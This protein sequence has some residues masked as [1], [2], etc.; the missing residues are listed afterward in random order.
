[1]LKKLYLKYGNRS[2]YSK[3]SIIIWGLT[4]TITLVAVLTSVIYY[5]YMANNKLLDTAKSSAQNAVNTIDINYT[6]IIERFVAAC[7]TEEFAAI[8]KTFISPNTSRTAREDMVQEVLN[9]LF[10]CNYMV[11]SALILSSDRKEYF[12]PYKNP[13]RTN[14]L[15]LFSEEELAS[16]DGITWLPERKSPFRNSVNV[17]PVVFPI[18][19]T[20]NGFTAISTSAE[21]PD[22]YVII[23]IESVKLTYSLALSGDLNT[24]STFF[25]VSPEGELF[26]SRSGEVAQ[27]VLANKEVF[28]FLK[29]F[30]FS[31]KANDHYNHPHYYLIASKL[32]RMDLLLVSFV[33][34]EHFAAM[35]GWTGVIILIVLLVIIL[36]MVIVSFLMAHY[37]TRPLNTLMKVVSQIGNNEYTQHIQ[38]ST[39]DEMGELCRAINSMHDTIQKQ[40]EQIKQEEAKKYM[41]EIKLLA[42]QI[43][44][45]F[46]YNTL[47]CIQ[48]EVIG[49][50][51]Q[52]AANMIQYLAEYLRIG[53]SYGD[54][55]IT[56]ANEL[57]HV[58]AYIKILNQRFQQSIIFMYQAEP[59]LDRHYMLKTILQPLVEN[60][61][62]YGFSIDGYGSVPISSPTIEI[63]FYTR[64]DLLHIEVI[65][66]GAGFDVEKTKEI[67][68]HD[69][70][71]DGS[72]HVGLHNIY[73][74]LV[75]YY[76][77]DQVAFELSSI[78][79]YRNSILMRFPLTREKQQEQSNIL[80][81]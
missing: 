70:N 67:L 38:F 59:G 44:P 32:E 36:I 21:D 10:N 8:F 23:L 12:S 34:K 57:R 50:R 5:R 68:Y 62:K 61:I 4:L 75:T 48:L 40:M 42:E 73:Y 74:R 25:I 14:L 65:D 2:L 55:L 77:E 27:K 26:N 60:S 49:G 45:H 22:A 72:R 71:S 29:N 31:S 3:I 33:E 41:S 39:N 20:D 43:N 58:H 76:G 6:D 1:M 52:S 9:T 37:I 7:G 66:N 16:I 79:Y 18:H 28:T 56:I 47:E 15:P 78:P 53:L 51:P 11:N 64:E 54:D 63:H 17:I 30:S 81:N 46:L 35:F 19:M 80:T 24:E 13:L 69:K